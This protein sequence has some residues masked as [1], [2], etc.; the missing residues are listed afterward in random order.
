MTARTGPGSDAALLEALSELFFGDEQAE[1]LEETL[2]RL[3]SPRF[4]QRINGKVYGRREYLGH[5]REMRAS[6]SGGRAEV[7]EQLRDGERVAGRY[8]FRVAQ[9]GGQEATFESCIF[10]QL[11]ADGRIERLAEVARVV[12]GDDDDDVMPTP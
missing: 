12:E 9:A 8:L 7:V 10:A 6:V 2:D 3:V 5:V 1:P 11:A 4:R